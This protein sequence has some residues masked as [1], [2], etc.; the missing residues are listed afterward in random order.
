M[1]TLGIIQARMGSTRLPRKMLMEL[2]QQPMLTRLLARVSSAQRVDHWLVATTLLPEDD[3]IEACARAANVACF[4]GAQ[5]DVLD[6]FY[7]AATPLNPV[8]VVRLTG[9]NPFVDHALV[10]W[11]IEQFEARSVD[12]ADTTQSHTFPLGLSV[13]G[14]SFAALAR[15]WREDHDP[16]TR[17]HVT[18]YLYRHPEHFRIAHLSNP[19]YREEQPRYRLTVDTP[20]DFAL[21]ERIYQHFGNGDF[22]WQAVVDLLDRRADLRALNH[23]IEQKQVP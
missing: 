3:A 22:D 12:Y 23:D 5:D 18:P 4:R 10:D 7:Q 13:E 17:E 15:A 6:R 9:D 14:F 11:V 1:K 2:N 16:A 19:A 21:A 20:Q 8:L